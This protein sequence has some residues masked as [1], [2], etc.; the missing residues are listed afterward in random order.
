M[1]I[2]YIDVQ[3][4]L[5]LRDRRGNNLATYP[6]DILSVMLVVIELQLMNNQI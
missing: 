1:K 4:V 6:D 3:S 2:K 5:N